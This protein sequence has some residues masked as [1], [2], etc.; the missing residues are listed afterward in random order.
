MKCPECKSRNY[1]R[2][3]RKRWMRSLPGTKY[4]CCRKCDYYFLVFYDFFALRMSKS[5]VK[6]KRI[7]LR[8]Y[9]S[10]DKKNDLSNESSFNDHV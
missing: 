10:I 2:V 5:R 7:I 9:Q 6:S 3:R 1:K 4:Y 8:Q